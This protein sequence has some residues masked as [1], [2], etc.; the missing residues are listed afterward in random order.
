MKRAEVLFLAIGGLEASR[1]EKTEEPCAFRRHPRPRILLIAA[2]IALM[3]LLVGCAVAVY[4]R[5]HM[6]LIQHTVPTAAVTLEDNPTLPNPL[7][8]CYPQQLPSG[9]MMAGGSPI[10]RASRN[11]RYCNDGGK[12]ISFSIST[13]KA[14]KGTLA[15][16]NETTTVQVSEWDAEMQVS[17]GGAQSLAWHNEKDG[18]Y[19]SLYTEDMSVDLIAMAESVAFGKELPLSFMC[20]QGTLWEVWYPQELPEGYRICQ[21]SPGDSGTKVIDYSSD[22]G[23]ITYCVSFVQ[24]LSDISDP[25]HDSCVWTE[26]TVAGQPGRMM[27]T[28][29]GLRLL[30]W[31]NEQE[32][33][34]AMLSVDDETVDIFA[35]AESVAPGAP[36]EVSSN[37][38][39]PDYSIEL[40]QD[41]DTYVGWEPVYPQAV[42][43][44]YAI[45]FVTNPAYG[46]QTIRYQNAA[47]D[48]MS[49]TIY[50]R[51]GEWGRQFSGMGQPQQ[52]DI[53]GSVGYL[54][55][56]GMMGNSLI[57]TDEAKGFAFALAAGGDVDLIAVAKSVGPGPELEPT[58]ADK[59]EKALEELGDYRITALP[60]GMTEDGLMGYPLEDGGGWYS[61]VRRWYFNKKTNQELFFTYES[62]VSDAASVEEVIQMN[63]GESCTQF[64]TIQGCT[65]AA[66]QDGN[67]A[68]VVWVQGDG[69]KGVCF[70]LT[71]PD[72]TP[73][74][75]L[76]LA[77][78]VRKQ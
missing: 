59:T 54:T 19:A 29:S 23:A 58:D 56:N 24:D 68:K 7:T 13:Q 47:G 6:R 46:E 51:L 30:F 61:Y 48:V 64:Q 45:A 74:E 36:L 77:E 12:S 9:Y 50:F 57:W 18:Y 40:E 69:A 11:I 16:P 3:M 21:V 49:Y 41:S 38:L 53:N 26:E 52:V 55:G 1:L 76:K 2:V 71:S 10:D 31:K 39:A 27:T 43:E 28:S 65:G 15:P 67:E 60:A 44:G 14:M 73:E 35:M 70:M 37:Y 20:K 72:Y 32:G 4:A 22:S 25:P 75:L 17:G 66:A 34:N 5:I 63:F 62:Y 33:F 78:S 42:P 8:G